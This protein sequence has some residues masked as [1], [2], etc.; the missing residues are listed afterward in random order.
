[1]LDATIQ[2]EE[3]YQLIAHLPGKD[4]GTDR[5]EQIALT[6]HADGPG[7]VQENGPYGFLSIVNYFSHLPQA[8]RNRTLLV[9]ID[10]RHF[11]PGHEWATYEIDYFYRH[12]ELLSPIVATIHIEMMGEM[13]YAERDGELVCTGRP[14]VTYLWTRNNHNLIEYGK[15]A[16]NR[17]QPGRMPLMVPEKPGKHGRPQEAWWGVNFIGESEKFSE[18]ERTITLDIPGYGLGSFGSS[19]YNSTFGMGAWNAAQHRKQLQVMTYLTTLLMGAD[20]S[21]LQSEGRVTAAN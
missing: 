16:L 19:Q 4:Y 3:V 8:E 11:M 14:E 1:M 10:S 20:L 7:L 21:Q 17:Y 2:E 18:D 13:E 5:D 6:T 12:P 9:Y 15:E